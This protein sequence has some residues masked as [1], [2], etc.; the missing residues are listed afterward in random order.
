MRIKSLTAW[1]ITALLC[2]SALA[3]AQKAKPV[4]DDAAVYLQDKTAFII[5][6]DKP[7]FVI[8]LKSNPTTGYSWFLRESNPE[9]F[10]AVKHQYEAPADKKLMGASGYELW[11]FR[12]KPAAFVVPQ[13]TA[14]RFIYTRPWETA[15]NATQIVFKVATV[16][17]GSKDE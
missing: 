4:V 5:S 9:L 11:T 13:Q 2:S 8:K 15:E 16:K 17:V 12:A 7:V 10:E 1:V 6:S 3:F 14:I